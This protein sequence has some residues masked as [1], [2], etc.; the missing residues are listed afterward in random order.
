MQITEFE[1][2]ENAQYFHCEQDFTK[3]L[4]FYIYLTDVDDQCGP[5]IYASKTH[6]QKKKN[7]RLFRL[8]SDNDIYNSYKDIK[9]FCANK[10]SFFFADSYGIHKGEKPKS[11]PRIILNVHYGANKIKYHRND[12]IVNI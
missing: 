11:K 7:H 5:H 2:Y 12:L 6:K 3:F 4:K 9:K 10:G 8:Y 1:K